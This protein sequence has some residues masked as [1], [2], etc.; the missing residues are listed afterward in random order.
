MGAA[1]AI[2]QSVAPSAAPSQTAC[3]LRCCAVC[4]LP[5]RCLRAAGSAVTALMEAAPACVNREN[6]GKK[7]K[8]QPS[9]AG[10]LLVVLL[11][12]VQV[13]PA[14]GA[15]ARKGA[16]DATVNVR[17]ARFRVQGL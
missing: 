1:D 7:E 12:A 2:S 8:M 10:A 6:T 11:A 9:L 4:A 15:P 16:V 14:L 5:L 17:P 3:S 13:G